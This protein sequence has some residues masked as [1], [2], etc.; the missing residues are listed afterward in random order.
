MRLAGAQTSCTFTYQCT[1]GRIC[2]G[3]SC[4]DVTTDNNNCGYCGN[5]CP[6]GQTCQGGACLGTGGCPSGTTFCNGGCT[7]TAYDPSN[8]GECGNRCPATSSCQNGECIGAGCPSGQQRCITSTSPYSYCADLQTDPNNCG[9]CENVCPDEQE[10]VGGQCQAIICPNPDGSQCSVCTVHPECF[11]WALASGGGS[12]CAASA[13][14]CA[15]S[16]SECN[17]LCVVHPNP[18]SGCELICTVPCPEPVP[19]HPIC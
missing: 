2:C 5:R 1:G 16:C 7:N 9:E 13:G 18:S 12:I 3:G 4:V 11:C 14:N 6:S 15:T 10:C 19:S 8:C 17:D